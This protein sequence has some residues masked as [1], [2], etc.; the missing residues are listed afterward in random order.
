LTAWN[1]H[2]N[3]CSMSA[4]KT[5]QVEPFVNANGRAN[6]CTADIDSRRVSANGR[7]LYDRRWTLCALPELSLCKSVVVGVCERSSSV[8]LTDRFK[9]R[10]LPIG[11]FTNSSCNVWSSNDNWRN[12]AKYP[13]SCVAL[14][15]MIRSR[16]S[17]CQRFS[18]SP[19]VFWCNWNKNHRCHN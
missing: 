6:L 19:I 16:Y 14:R 3:N 7:L 11:R 18:N 1:I 10:L 13:R 15:P 8:K 5:P 2:K 9:Y 17:I 4:N 12:K